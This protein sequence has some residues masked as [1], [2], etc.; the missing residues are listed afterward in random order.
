MSLQRTAKWDAFSIFFRIFVVLIV[1]LT[2]VAVAYAQS[3]AGSWQGTLPVGQSPRV[4]LK[5]V[6]SGNGDLRGSISFVD[7]SAD[8]VPLLSTTYKAPNLTAA[9]S[10]ITFHGK[11]SADGKSIAGT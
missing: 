6:D 3:I 2:S 4:V 1:S 11:L 7:K 5:I 8:A 9:I 10:D